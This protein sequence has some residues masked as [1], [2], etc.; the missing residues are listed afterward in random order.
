M[1]GWGE[2]SE[3]AIVFRIRH[4]DGITLAD[5]VSYDGRAFDL[6]EVKELGRR[7]GLDLRATAQGE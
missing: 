6:K 1:R 5:R 4:M 7:H 2:S 3:A